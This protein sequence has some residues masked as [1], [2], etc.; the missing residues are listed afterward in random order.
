MQFYVMRTNSMKQGLMVC[1]VLGVL[2][3]ASVSSLRADTEQDLIEILRSNT[4][5]AEKCEACRKL[6]LVGTARSVP[7]LA[8]LLG[9]DR[10]SQAARYALE[11]IPAPEATVALR[12][13]VR[14]LSGALKAGV[15]D[16]LGWR[17]D[18]ESVPLLTSLLADNDPMIAS[19]AAGAL[20]RIGGKEAAQGLSEAF[21]KATPAVKHRI[22]D[23]LLQ[24]AEQY[25]AEG[26]PEAANA[27]YSTLIRRVD[28]DHVRVAANAGMILA[29]GDRAPTV[30]REALLGQDVTAQMAA[31][32]LAGELQDSAITGVL[33]DLLPRLSPVL[34]VG[35]IGA[36]QQR[37]DLAARDVVV[38]ALGSPEPSVR[39]AALSALGVLGDASVVPALVEAAKSSDEAVQRT[40]RESLVALRHGDVAAALVMHIPKSDPAAQVEIVRALTARNERSAVK[41]LIA[42]AQSD[43]ASTRK[44]ALQAIANLADASHL[45]ALV[46]LLVMTKDASALQDV[47]DAVESVAERISADTNLDV[48]PLVKALGTSDP[49][50]RNALLQ[51]SALFAHERIRDV[52][53][54][55]LKDQNERIRVAA[56]RALCSTRDPELVPDLLDLARGT[57]DT[58][59]KSM[60]ITGYVRLVSDERAGFDT[61]KRAELLERVFAIAS[62]AQEKKAVLSALAGVADPRSLRLA[63]EAAREPD[64]RREAEVACL[65]A[66]TA[67]TGSHFE[68]AERA[69]NKLAA[70]ALDATVRTNAQSALKR[71]KSGWVCTGPYRVAGKQAQDLFDVVFP[72]EE[73]GLDRL[74]WRRAPGSPD[75]SREGEVDLGTVVGGDHCV[76]YLKTRVYSPKDQDVTFSI[77]SDDGIKLWVN[78]ELVHANN[79]V[80]GLVPGQD[81]AKGK[82]R[83]GWNDLFAKITQHTLGCGLNLR[84]VGTDGAPIPGIV[85]DPAGGNER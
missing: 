69:L 24:C 74:E 4:N 6:R 37:G 52:F 5:A 51:V 44:A 47:Q 49:D 56:A 30:F 58:D 42:L 77:G 72:P 3:F 35:V 43:A 79:A 36:L 10:V 50:T 61:A 8:E 45:A 15:I 16:S 80:R 73:G 78:G 53:R 85:F 75:L 65:Q 40:A 60:A 21:D 29:A 34:Q 2:Q 62:R 19:A 41:D 1:L 84:I 25:R 70:E 59:I 83:A 71:M 67:L 13:A 27:I 9:D 12:R 7:A 31:L 33:T 63:E 39:V 14:G 32:R 76:V 18:S 38:A 81:K 11:G 57:K 20:G 46:D 82:L 26:N 64:V 17:R 54:T 28:S 48:T 23:A 68:L 55:A 66:A 22:A